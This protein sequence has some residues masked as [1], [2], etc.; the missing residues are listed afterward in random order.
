LRAQR[1]Q[2]PDTERMEA[3]RSA[4]YLIVYARAI[5]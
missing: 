1:I 3:V 4:D 2:G 5:A